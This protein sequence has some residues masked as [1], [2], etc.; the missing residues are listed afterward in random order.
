MIPFYNS[1]V[2]LDIA[3]LPAWLLVFYFLPQ[4]G[5]VIV[6]AAGLAGTAAG[7]GIV[8]VGM[9]ASTLAYALNCHGVARNFGKGIG[10]ACGIFFVP[11][12]FLPILAFGKARYRRR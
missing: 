9:L 8:A 11:F 1:V 5:A 7:V 4:I 12:V 3:G 10:F 2:F 6:S